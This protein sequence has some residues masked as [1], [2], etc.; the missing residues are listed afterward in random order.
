MST[1]YIATIVAF[2]SFGL[3]FLGIQVVDEGSLTEFITQL[4][5]VGAILYSFYGRYRAGGIDALGLRK[6]SD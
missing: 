5:G 3:P 4:V 1:T 6:T 2:L